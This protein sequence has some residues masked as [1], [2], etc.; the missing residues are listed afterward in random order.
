MALMGVDAH[1]L[2]AVELRAR[3]DHVSASLDKAV[4]HLV[5]GEPDEG[6]DAIR[7][8]LA[9]VPVAREHWQRR[10]ELAVVAGEWDLAAQEAQ[11]SLRSFADRY[12]SGYREYSGAVL[13]LIAGDDDHAVTRV[14]QLKRYIA[15]HQ[16]FRSGQPARVAD[17]PAGLVSRDAERVAAGLEALLAWHLR[18]ARARSEV[19]NSSQGILCLDAVVALLLA[20][21]RGLSVPVRA[22]YRA[23]RLPLLAIHLVEWRGEPLARGLPLAVEAD[24]V[25]G[26]WLRAQGIRIADPPPPSRPPT[27]RRPERRLGPSDVDEAA[28]CEDLQRREQAG[29]GSTWQLASWALMLGDAAGGREHLR[30][31]AQR[32]RRSWQATVPPPSGALRWL[33]QS[34][35]LPNHNDLRRHFGLA[36]ALGDEDALRETSRLIQAWMTAV[37]EDARRRGQAAPPPPG[38]Y[39]HAVGYL[40]LLC[41]L[42]GPASRHPTREEAERVGALLPDIPVACIGLVERDRDLFERGL[43]GVL[44]EH[45]QT[46]ERRT[47]P[48][49]PVCEPAV[50]L[51]VA[52]RRLG[53]GFTA[54]GRY[55]SYPVPIV[56]RDATGGKGRLGRL[57]CDLLGMELW[58]S[59]RPA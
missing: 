42:L 34:Q 29:E 5:C 17:I 13:A 52:A 39:T 9:V 54:E 4:W 22:M 18:R 28:V 7:R 23:A 24:L 57:P 32:A 19:F 6:L 10:A 51:A 21:R 48:P 2:L 46:L 30:S 3:R 50:H 41:D 40:D 45:A 43:N 14:Q 12:V 35:A 15:T 31:E 47:S 16:K 56:V 38:R 58:A 26:P 53:V 37:E 11:L 59:P 8:S 27:L 36:L 33:R 1:E 25:A 55:R 44:G 49:P 20:H